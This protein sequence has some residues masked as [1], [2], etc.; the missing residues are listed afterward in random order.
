MT[1]ALLIA[2]T[3]IVTFLAIVITVLNI[4][5]AHQRKNDA[6]GLALAT[7][8]WVAAIFSA[9]ILVLY[10]TDAHQLSLTDILSFYGTIASVLVSIED[11][12]SSKISICGSHRNI[13]AIHNSCFCPCDREPP[14]SPITVSYPSGSFFIKL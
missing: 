6:S 11:V 8:L 13:L 12:A 14:P 9:A 7:V 3:I 5:H 2:I 4:L 1:L 10:R